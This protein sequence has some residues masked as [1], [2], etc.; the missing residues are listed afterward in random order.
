[1]MTYEMVMEL[2]ATA[3]ADLSVDEC[4]DRIYVTVEDFDGFD[5]SWDEIMRDL[6]DEELVDSIYEQL[7]ASAVSASGDFYRY[8]DFDGF[9]IVWGS[10]SFDI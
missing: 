5:E 3:G 4:G 1:M 9:T 6:D 7:E 10:A 8:F 2:L